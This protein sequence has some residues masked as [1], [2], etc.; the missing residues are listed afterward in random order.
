MKKYKKTV[1]DQCPTISEIEL[2]YKT[3]TKA[4]E[5][6]QVSQSK[7][8]FNYLMAVWNENA[9][10][11]REEAYILLMNTANK[12]IGWYK[13]SSGGT[14]T[15]VLDPKIVFQLA[16]LSN[17]SALIVAH[18]HPSGNLNPS[19]A[20]VQLTD[21]LKQSGEMLGIKVLD[22]LIVT[23]EKTYFSFGDEGLI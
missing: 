21:N 17:A 19:Q 16:L 2:I 1:V 8:A 12:I 13:L 4:S 15:T 14:A 5:R 11:H 18:N 23:G 22:H 7:D 20:D 9:I 6:P 3:K 10:E